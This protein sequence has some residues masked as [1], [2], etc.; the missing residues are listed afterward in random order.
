[1]SNEKSGAKKK[2]AE[3]FFWRNQLVILVSDWKVGR[4]KNGGM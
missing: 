2:A 4:T 3:K 1:M